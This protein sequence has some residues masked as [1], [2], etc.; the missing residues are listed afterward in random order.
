MT[1]DFAELQ[2]CGKTIKGLTMAITAKENLIRAIR[3]EGPHYVPWSIQGTHLYPEYQHLDPGVIQIIGIVGNSP[4][5]GQ[6]LVDNWG[7]RQGDIRWR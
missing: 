5:F 4:E 6:E 3:R 1:F 7:S 2:E